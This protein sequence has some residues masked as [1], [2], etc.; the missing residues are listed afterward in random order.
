MIRTYFPL[1]IFVHLVNHRLQ[2]T[3]C[4]ILSKGLHNLCQFVDVDGA[5]AIFIEELK[6]LFELCHLRRTKRFRVSGT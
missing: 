1:S 4:R 3:S 2:F 6:R 5:T